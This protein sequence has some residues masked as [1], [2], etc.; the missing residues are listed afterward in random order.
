MRALVQ[1]VSR[2]KVTVADEVTGAIEAGLCVFLGIKEGDTQAL[3]AKLAEKISNLR[4]FPD[5][6][7]KM[8]RSVLEVG[9]GLLIVSQFTLYG[10]TSKGNRPSYI[11]AARPE[12][13]RELYEYFI[14]AC[15]KLCFHVASGV[16]QA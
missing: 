2:A 11:Q 10:D 13:A 14:A 16:F 8:N 9:G 7:G 15:Q 12:M 1:R 5:A 4:I 6:E 3:A